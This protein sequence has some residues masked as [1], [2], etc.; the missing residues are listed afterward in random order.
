MS[1]GNYNEIFNNIEKWLLSHKFIILNKSINPNSPVLFNL[2]TH[3]PNDKIFQINITLFKETN[4]YFLLNRNLVFDDSAIRSINA[5]PK[6]ERERL[7]MNI[8][9]LIY[10][11]FVNLEMNW[12]KGILL[13]KELTIDSIKNNE[14]LFIDQVRN[15]RNAVELVKINF[16][17]KHFELFP[18]GKKNSG[19]FK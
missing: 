14:Q 17:E 11:L 4:N 9:K 13:L 10:P 5:L 12:P 8:R 7:F 1:S 15:L 2:T 3:L 6:G 16:D 19:D 18:Q